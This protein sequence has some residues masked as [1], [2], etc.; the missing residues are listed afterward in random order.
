MIAEAFAHAPACPAALR[1]VKTKHG[2]RRG[3]PFPAGWT[4]G[5]AG[6]MAG[7][8]RACPSATASA[9]VGM[10]RLPD[11]APRPASIRLM[12]AGAAAAL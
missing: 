6:R 12:A 2:V 11:A 10:A 3:M 9:A 1:G 5:A 4:T 8:A 7:Q